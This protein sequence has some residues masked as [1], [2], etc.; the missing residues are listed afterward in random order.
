MI[1]IQVHYTYYK[2]NTSNENLFIPKHNIRNL[3]D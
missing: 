2:K 1:I 3:N